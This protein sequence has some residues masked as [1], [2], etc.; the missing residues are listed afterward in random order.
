MGKWKVSL[1]AIIGVL[2]LALVLFGLNHQTQTKV[3][4]NTTQSNTSSASSGSANPQVKVLDPNAAKFEGQDNLTKYE[5]AAQKNSSNPADQVN[6]AQSAFVNKDYNKAIEYYKKA[7][8]LDP[9]NAKYL[10]Y[11]GNVYYRG[12][13]N[14]QEASQYYQSATQ[15]DPHYAYGWLNLA[16]C[17]VALGNKNAA[18]T[19]LQ[20]GI[21]GLD[22]KD[23]MLQQLQIELNTLK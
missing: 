8:A 7:V 4:A 3:P 16:F 22:P 20:K 1:G 6:A 9:K 12:L 10:T 15:N 11:L 21:A 18:K 19:T 14:P 13:N 2:V 17:E 23:P 5:N